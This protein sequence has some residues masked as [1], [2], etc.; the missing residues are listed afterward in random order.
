MFMSLMIWDNHVNTGVLIIGDNTG[1]LHNVLDMKGAGPLL[2][3]ARELAW[4]KVRQGWVL[5]VAHIPTEHNTAPY[6]LSRQFDTEPAPFPTA[7]CGT[8]MWKTI[9]ERNNIIG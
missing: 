8:G 1:S 2:A 4:R 9:T 3:V 6:A 7:L 5:D